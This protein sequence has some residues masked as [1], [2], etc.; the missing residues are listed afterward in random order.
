MAARPRGG[1]IYCESCKT[2]YTPCVSEEPRRDGGV[3]MQFTCPHCGRI[4]PVAAITP[5]G[6]SLRGRLQQMARLGQT[7]KPHYMALL[8]RY[9]KQVTPLSQTATTSS[10][11]AAITIAE[12]PHT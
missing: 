5:L 9:R 3:V 11:V 1:V 8:A 12:A 10:G 2:T 6:I 4:Y 7:G